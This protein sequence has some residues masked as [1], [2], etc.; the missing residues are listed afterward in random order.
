MPEMPHEYDLDQGDGFTEFA[1]AD[2]EVDEYVRLPKAPKEPVT[3]RIESFDREVVVCAHEL[4]RALEEFATKEP[5][6]LF[7]T[8][9]EFER[10]ALL[11]LDLIH[12]EGT[13]CPL[14]GR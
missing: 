8:T 1:R 6:Q 14:K 11:L 13:R 12:P 2:E 10:A 9:N 7:G 3:A 4:A 5:V